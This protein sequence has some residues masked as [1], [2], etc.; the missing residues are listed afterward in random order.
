MYYLTKSKFV[1]RLFLN[2]HFDLLIFFSD[3]SEISTT[4]DNHYTPI[5]VND[6]IHDGGIVDFDTFDH[7]LTVTS[8]HEAVYAY[9]YMDEN[10]KVR[11]ACVFQRM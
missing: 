4:I 1:D 7:I 9:Y 2:S 8:E 6:G 10:N 3:Y 11:G 5:A